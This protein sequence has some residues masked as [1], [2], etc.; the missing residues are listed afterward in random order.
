MDANLLYSKMLSLKAKGKQFIL[1]LTKETIK[2][3]VK[4]EI[5]EANMDDVNTADMWFAGVHAYL[6]KMDKII[7]IEGEIWLE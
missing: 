1:I 5:P 6:G 3:L 4:N 2:Q 7:L